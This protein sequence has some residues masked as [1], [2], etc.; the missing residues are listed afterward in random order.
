[1]KREEARRR[2]YILAA[3]AAKLEAG[4]VANRLSAYALLIGE[5]PERI[6]DAC[7]DLDE[8]AEQTPSTSVAEVLREASR[9]VRGVLEP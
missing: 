9:I 4:R 7:A 5:H 1:M 6:A 8:L 3:R 2:L